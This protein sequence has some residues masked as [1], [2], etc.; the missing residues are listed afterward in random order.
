MRA[1]LACIVLCLIA[2]PALARHHVRHYRHRHVYSTEVPVGGNLVKVSSAAGP[3]VVAPDFEQPILGFIAD[4]VSMGF[5][6]PV[7]CY[8]SGGHVAHSNHY[9]GHACDFAQTGWGRTVRPMYHVADLA[10]KWGLRD[11]CTFTDCGHID[12][13]PSYAQGYRYHDGPQPR[14]VEHYVGRPDPHNP[15]HY[16]AKQQPVRYGWDQQ[17]DL[18][19]HE[20]KQAVP[21][22]PGRPKRSVRI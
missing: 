11:G 1:L 6:G 17:H 13:P 8:A 21:S 12:M 15:R 10:H 4:V 9:T 14:A 3:I 18:S 7:H 2:S 19:P 20:W 5:R 16:S 22:L